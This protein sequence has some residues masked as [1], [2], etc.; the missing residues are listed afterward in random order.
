MAEAY[1]GDE[2]QKSPAELMVEIYVKI[3][4]LR[5]SSAAWWKRVVIKYVLMNMCFKFDEFIFFS[6]YFSLND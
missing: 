4:F 5:L 1:L 2:S 3:I 6:L